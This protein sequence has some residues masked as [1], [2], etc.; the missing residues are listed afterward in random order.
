MRPVRSSIFV[1]L[2]P[3]VM[4]AGCAHHAAHATALA[5][6]AGP[7]PA[8][9][10]AP[11][12]TVKA[13]VQPASSHLG[14]SGDLAAACKLHFTAPAEAP[15]FDFDTSTLAPDDRDVLTAIATCLTSGPL[16][17]RRIELVGRADPRGTEEY[18][19]ALGER[20][21]ASVSEY[22]SHLGVAITRMADTTR[23]ALDATGHDEASWRTDRRVDL[24]LAD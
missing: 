9:I 11:R 23:G 24:Q 16:A 15:K 2:A 10:V 20:R 12:T 18:N 4:A 17:G 3:A 6:P 5:T 21:A 14:V 8:R 13:D 1:A 22:L 19:L 7:P